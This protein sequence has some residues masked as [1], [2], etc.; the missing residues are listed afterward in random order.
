MTTYTFDATSSYEKRNG[1]DG[2]ESTVVRPFSYINDFSLT[3][4]VKLPNW[5]QVIANGHC[6]TTPRSGMKRHGSYKPAYFNAENDEGWW[7]NGNFSNGIQ[8]SPPVPQLLTTMSSLE[9]EALSRYVKN[10]QGILN[11][12]QGLTFLGELNEVL[13]Q[14]KNPAKTLRKRVQTHIHK[15]RK[16]VRGMRAGSAKRHRVVSDTWLEAVFGWQPLIGDIDSGMDAL[17]RWY[18]PAVRLIPVVGKAS[19]DS[20]E[21][22][23]TNTPTYGP[24]H[25]EIPQWDFHHDKVRYRGRV[26]W[27]PASSQDSWRYYGLSWR[28][29]LPTAWELIPYSF[30][31]D[32]FTNIGDIVSAWSAGRSYIAWTD[33]TRYRRTI[34][35]TI[36][37]TFKFWDSN[38]KVGT[39]FVQPESVHFTSFRWDRGQ[40]FGSLVPDFTW[41]IPGVGSKKWLNLAA[42]SLGKAT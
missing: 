7:W 32:Y 12:F 15:T 13:R 21:W 30:A 25:L 35:R 6:A 26:R 38:Y 23:I 3:A 2:S 33:R 17:T 40:Y 37:G 4:S 11:A 5:R 41:E 20:K 9:Q 34:R 16:K 10:A 29:V 22:H 31:V 27:D 39:H 42:L 24:L 18:D 8:A 14:I 28:D 19:D 36:N 1:I